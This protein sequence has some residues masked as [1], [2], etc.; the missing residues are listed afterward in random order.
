[1]CILLF[2]FSLCIMHQVFSALALGVAA[3]ELLQLPLGSLPPCGNI[4]LKL[5]PDFYSNNYNW[6]DP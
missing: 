3:F 1:M 6:I 4:L 2:Y 5:D